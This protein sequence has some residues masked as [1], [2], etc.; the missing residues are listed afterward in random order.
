MDIT[1]EQSF[2]HTIHIE[3][4][5]ILDIDERCEKLKPEWENFACPEVEIMRF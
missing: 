1:T 5:K 4:D 3:E 2:H